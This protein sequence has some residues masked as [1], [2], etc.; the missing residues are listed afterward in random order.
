LCELSSQEHILFFS[1]FAFF[2]LNE[3]NP[4]LGSLRLGAKFYEYSREL[5]RNCVTFEMYMIFD[6]KW[7]KIY[8]NV[9]IENLDLFRRK[10]S[11]VLAIVICEQK[12]LTILCDV[13]VAF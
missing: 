4:I 2:V 1:L 11:T 12:I 8:M 7:K 5:S 9:D 6:F 3:E 13:N 10:F